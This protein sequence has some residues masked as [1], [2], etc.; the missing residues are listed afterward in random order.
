[1]KHF[2]IKIYGIVQ[3]VGFRYHAIRQANSIGVTGFVRN[4][5]DGSVY[6][7]AEGNETALAEFVK[8]C[9]T[10]PSYAHVED[11]NVKEGNL[12]NFTLFEARH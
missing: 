10:G 2:N 8:W 3:G 11:V 6:I 12:K 4:E 9:K 7:E 1:M 5:P